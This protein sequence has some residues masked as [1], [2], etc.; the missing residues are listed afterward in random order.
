MRETDPIARAAALL[1]ASRAAQL[2]AISIAFALLPACAGTRARSKPNSQISPATTPS[3]TARP[4]SAPGTNALA[5]PQAPRAIGTAQRVADANL[6]AEFN[7]IQ[8][9]GDVYFAGWPTED[10]I[11]ALA[12]RGVRTIIALKSIDEIRDARGYDARLAAAALG[13]DLVVIPVSPK[14]FS[15][16]DVQSFATAFNAASGP[17]L[18]HCGSS[19]TVGGV[20]AAYLAAERGVSATEAI[21]RG[22]AA[23]LRE[24]PMSDAAER[25]I[26]EASKTDAP[27][28]DGPTSDASK[29]GATPSAGKVQ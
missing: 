18:I 4:E 3:S 13:V 29:A 14:S 15:V 16:Q 6:A 11:R 27:K 17:V 25:V 9:D 2:L 23:G 10:G 1:D 19:N 7:N 8:Q 24:G 21:E 20:W 28:A 22:R 12:A 5:T 26:R